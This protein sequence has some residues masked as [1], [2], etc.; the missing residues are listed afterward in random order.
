MKLLLL[1]L[2]SM[3]ELH[4]QDAPDFWHG[5]VKIQWVGLPEYRTSGFVQDMKKEGW[6]N[7]WR[8]VLN[9]PAKMELPPKLALV[10]TT[11]AISTGVMRVAADMLFTLE[12]TPYDGAIS[13]GIVA[14]NSAYEA[15]PQ[16][17]SLTVLPN[18]DLQ[19]FIEETPKD[20]DALNRVP[21]EDWS[22]RHR[23]SFNLLSHAH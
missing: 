21:T 4:A 17:V 2:I 15:R 13:K 5:E 16:N 11:Q 9:K 8:I 1:L 7:R 18:G 6:N 23:E 22:A 19:I 3:S 14:A 12:M 20:Y 10:V